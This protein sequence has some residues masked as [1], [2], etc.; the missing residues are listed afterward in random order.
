MFQT[1]E[2]NRR[3]SNKGNMILDGINKSVNMSDSKYKEEQKSNST[4]KGQCLI[5]FDKDIT[6][7]HSN[8]INGIKSDDLD[9][10]TANLVNFTGDDVKGDT[11]IIAVIHQYG[12]LNETQEIKMKLLADNFG[13]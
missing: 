2:V 9:V 11:K 12:R 3:G 8:F 1:L 7:F 4:P 6:F 13:T 10:K 5:L